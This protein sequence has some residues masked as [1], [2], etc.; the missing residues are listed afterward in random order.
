MPGYRRGPSWLAQAIGR[1]NRWA[2]PAQRAAQSKRGSDA[3]KRL[4]PEE[5]SER[6]RKAA[7]ARWAKARQEREEEQA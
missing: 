7:Q 2:D 3:A 4:T 5:R 6:A 1:R